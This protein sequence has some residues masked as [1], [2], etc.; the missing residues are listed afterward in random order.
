VSKVERSNYE[1]EQ[2]KSLSLGNGRV[3]RSRL[4]HQAEVSPIRDRCYEG[5]DVGEGV[6]G[7]EAAHERIAETFFL[8]GGI[9]H[10]MPVHLKREKPDFR[11]HQNDLGD[12]PGTLAVID[13]LRDQ[14]DGERY[15]GKK[16]CKEQLERVGKQG[17]NDEK[18]SGMIHKRF[19]CRSD[20]FHQP[21]VDS[22]LS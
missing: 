2:R 12:D 6:D 13:R 21:L 8:G 18:P 10:L 1:R 11:C 16:T 20:Q 22:G 4:A 3:F 9:R 17:D 15:Y 7:I 5:G 19:D 14:R